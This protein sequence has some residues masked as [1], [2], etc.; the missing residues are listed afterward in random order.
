VLEDEAEAHHMKTCP[1]CQ[2]QWPDTGK[3]CPMDGTPLVASD[4]T[5]PVPSTIVPPVS[6]APESAHSKNTI[7]MTPSDA[8]KPKKK[9]SDTK[10]FLLGDQIKDED[11]EPEEVP[12]DELQKMYKTTKEMPVEVR[13]KFSLE[14]KDDDKKGQG[15]KK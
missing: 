10:W 3:F 13:R 11:R 6:D 4:A 12:P 5:Q 1:K 9:F 7:I 8:P 2:N 14:Y 15:P